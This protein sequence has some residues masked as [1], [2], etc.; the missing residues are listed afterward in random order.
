MQLFRHNKTGNIYVLLHIGK[1][2]TN[3]REGAQV[4]VY[5]YRGSDNGEI[6]VRELSEFYEKFTEVFEKA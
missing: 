1:D 5:R 3:C 4:A 2:C 6:F